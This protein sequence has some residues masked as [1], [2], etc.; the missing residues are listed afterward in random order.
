MIQ[1]CKFEGLILRSQLLHILSTRY[2]EDGS[3]PSSLW[4]KVT[5]GSLEEVSV[6]GEPV[7]PCFTGTKV[8]AYWY[9]STNTDT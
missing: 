8:L 4:Y 7:L 6:D 9:K 3:E 1:D 2:S 5:V